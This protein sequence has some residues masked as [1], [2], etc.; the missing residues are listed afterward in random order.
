MPS[1]F[2]STAVLAASALTSLLSVPALAQNAQGADEGNGS[3][4]VVTLDV[5]DSN[6]LPPPPAGTIYASHGINLQP[7]GLSFDPPVVITFDHHPD[8]I[9]AAVLGAVRTEARP[10][11]RDAFESRP[12]VG[13]EIERPFTKQYWPGSIAAPR[14]KS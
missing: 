9:E 10:V 7:E 14:T 13:K 4:I 5:F 12:S 1:P 2:L 6:A 8:E 11:E 3:D